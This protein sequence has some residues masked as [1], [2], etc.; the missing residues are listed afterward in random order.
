MIDKLTTL[1]ENQKLSA[2]EKTFVSDLLERANSRGD[3]FK[4]SE[5]Q[6]AV[7]LK[8]EKERGDK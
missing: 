3:D 5:K 1:S 4:L 8:I 7:I 6:E 2:W